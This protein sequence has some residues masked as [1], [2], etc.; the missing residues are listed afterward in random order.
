MDLGNPDSSQCNSQCNPLQRLAAFGQSVWLDY[1]ER[2]FVRGGRLARLIA[3]DNVSGVTS[4]PAIFHKAIVEHGT[5][6]D[7]IESLARAGLAA[8]EIQEALIVEDVREAADVLANV[9]ERSSGHDGFVSLEVSPHF[10]R[11]T[12][13]TYWEAKRLWTLVR[14]A[15][16]MVKVPGTK[17]GVGAIRSLV[18]DGI[19]VNIT[20][21]FSV[22]RYAAV[23]DAYIAGLEDRVA[24]RQPIERI[25]SV[26]S[27]F[28]SRI[29]TL[30]DQQ[31]ASA[32]EPQLRAMRGELAIACARAAYLHFVFTMA[33]SRWREL[34]FRGAHPQRLLWASTG[35]KN[36]AYSDVKYV[37]ALVGP[38]TVTTL[39]LETLCAY[40][41]HGA[42][43]RRLGGRQPDLDALLHGL[44]AAGIEWE[45]L[46]ARL[47][48][49]GIEKFI[50]P[51]EATLA[52]L[53]ACLTARSN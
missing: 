42:P 25:A 23:A 9:Y 4:N 6:D 7:A 43:A 38:D 19:N 26:A 37:D 36:P 32:E 40:R 27:L 1:I 35:T 34:A 18:A 14:R 8:H 15:N 41:D 21:L 47:E 11:D 52:A 48:E 5:Y 44:A 24:R 50:E 29:D 13:G 51:H 12:E 20:L 53:R 16:L 2:E 45:P 3:Q 33:S 46:A 28:L 22:E 39:P 17:E 10:A 30:I 49:E 31:L